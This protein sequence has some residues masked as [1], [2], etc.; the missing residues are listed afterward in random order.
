MSDNNK[1]ESWVITEINKDT[2]WEL[3]AQAKAQCG[4]DMGAMADHLRDQ[5]VAMGPQQAQRFHDILHIY[6]DLAK[7]YGLWDAA[8]IMKEYGCSDDGFIDFRAWL[9]AQGKDVYLDAL[10]DPDSLADVEP[11]G[12]CSFECMS[13]VGDSAYEQLTGESAYDHMDYAAY[14]KL[15]E[16]LGADIAYREDIQYPRNPR[17]LPSAYPKLCAKYG[18]A[19][20]F[21]VDAKVW[22]SDLYEIRMMLEQGKLYD[23][24]KGKSKKKGGKTR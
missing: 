6:E 21:N 23:S 7:K 22:N 16:E 8:S 2:F 15:T 12:D 4:Q 18:G 9:I 11:Y 5:L 13:Y 14:E 3:I 24:Q 20:R 10:R 19:E 17:D 1:T